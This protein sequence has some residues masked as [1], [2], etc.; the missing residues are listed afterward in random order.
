[1]YISEEE[2]SLEEELDIEIEVAEETF[3]DMM[4]HEEM[5]MYLEMEVGCI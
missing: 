5:Q 2:L 1:M 3:I 4:Q